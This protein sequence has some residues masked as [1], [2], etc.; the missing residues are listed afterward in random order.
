MEDEPHGQERWIV[1]NGVWHKFIFGPSV[2]W[3][4]TGEDGKLEEFTGD[5][6]QSVNHL[7]LDYDANRLKY[8]K[9]HGGGLG[10]LNDWTNGILMLVA[11]S[12]VGKS[13]HGAIFGLLRTI[14]CEGH[15]DWAIFKHNGVTCPEYRGPRRLVISS[16]SWGNVAEVWDEYRLWTPRELLGPYAPGW[17]SGKYENESG[18]ERT[19]SFESGKSQRLRLKDGS[20]FIFLCD[21][22]RQGPWEG[23]R[24]DDHHVDEQR[25]KEKWIGYLRGTANTKG[26]VQAAFTLTGHIVPDRPD[27]GA[28][29]WVHMDLWEGRYTYGK[30]V[31]RY[32]IGI[33]DVP[34]AVLGD[35]RR[36]ELREQWVDAP[37]RNQDEDM[38]RKATARYWGG[39]ETGGGLVLHNFDPAIHVV[40]EFNL[41]HNVFLDATKFRAIDHGLGRPCAMLCGAMFPW[42]DLV[43]YREYYQ[44]GKNV[45]YN[46]REIVKACGNTIIQDSTWNDPTGTASY[47]ILR[48]K[49][50]TEE[51]DYSVLDGRDFAKPTQERSITLG[52]LYN[53]C[54]LFCTAATCA[55]NIKQEG[56]SGLIPN[57]I[58]LL[59]P[60]RDRPH[61]MWHLWKRDVIS[62]TDYQA[63][64]K[65]RNGDYMN[66]ARLYFVRSLRWT[67]QEVAQWRFDHETGLPVGEN[68]HL[69]SCLR[70]IVGD[71]PAYRGTMWKEEIEE[72]PTMEETNAITKRKYVGWF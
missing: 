5:R 68:D 44:K 47:A 53:D 31:G 19:I 1:I 33:D 18:C 36:K 50:T 29:S 12:R 38:L 69:M 45:P 22:Q 9:P 34:K 51:Y 8:F 30:T 66:G 63:W 32:K 2:V 40:P 28:G 42:G 39:W 24:F 27:T 58:R 49:F 57:L 23:K 55:W 61:L 13:C 70:Y 26:L 67:F 64:L 43:I 52:Q 65:P 15:D 41:K 62:T 71:N 46:A 14:K 17:G 59:T 3:H 4:Q 16:Y 35:V 72:W 37:E 10:F 48:E 54:G 25:Q 7:F 21:Q 60:E 11:P 6:I 56:R 20:E